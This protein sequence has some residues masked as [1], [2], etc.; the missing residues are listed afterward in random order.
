MFDYDSHTIEL[1]AILGM[2][3]MVFGIVTCFCF[4]INGSQ[5]SFNRAGENFIKIKDEKKNNGKLGE[6]KDEI[7]IKFDENMK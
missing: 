4:C 1:F 7:P 5:N 2:M 6:K 3:T